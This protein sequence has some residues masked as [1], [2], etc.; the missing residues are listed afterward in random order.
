MWG[1]LWVKFNFWA[2]II[3]SVGIL[4]LID[5]PTFLTQDGAGL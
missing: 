1:N 5:P 4:Q 3:S 2:P